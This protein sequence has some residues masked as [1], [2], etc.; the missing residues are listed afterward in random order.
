MFRFIRGIL[1]LEPTQTTKTANATVASAI[2]EGEF[3]SGPAGYSPNTQYSDTQYGSRFDENA[4][5]A[6]GEH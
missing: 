2:N 3:R 6:D 5:W 4:D 1:G